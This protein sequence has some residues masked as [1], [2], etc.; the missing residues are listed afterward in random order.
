MET[1]E[2]CDILSMHT[3]HCKWRHDYPNRTLQNNQTTSIS[4]QNKIAIQEI[5]LNVHHTLKRHYR[6]TSINC[7]KRYMEYSSLSPFFGRT[8]Q[9]KNSWFIS[10]ILLFEMSAND[11]W[12][13]TYSGKNVEPNL[14]TAGSTFPL[15]VDILETSNPPFLSTGLKHS[16]IWTLCQWFAVSCQ[17]FCH[18]IS[19]IAT[20]SQSF[21][22]TC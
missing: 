21:Q 7:H 15:S 8:L 14:W 19:V 11:R 1:V 3:W 4:E 17:Y 5:G 20:V 13:W 18:H 9:K 10:L 12:A 22:W 16:S 2:G 6:R